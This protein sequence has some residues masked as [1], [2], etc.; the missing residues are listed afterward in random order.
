MQRRPVLQCLTAAGAVGLLGSAGAGPPEDDVCA[1]GPAAFAGSGPGPRADA[2][3]PAVELVR[4]HGAVAASAA[5]AAAIRYS[6]D[7][8]QS[9]AAERSGN[10]RPADRVDRADRPP[11]DRCPVGCNASSLSRGS[12]PNE[13]RRR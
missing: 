7:L 2:A 11:V 8:D 3:A 10:L 5:L 9:N 12:L 4:A 13:E 6:L 1:K